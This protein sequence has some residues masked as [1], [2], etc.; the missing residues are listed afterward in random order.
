[1]RRLHDVK[2]LWK[3][4]LKWFVEHSYNPIPQGV[5]IPIL[6]YSNTPILQV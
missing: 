3:N 6:H 1:M 2:D 5:F 4:G